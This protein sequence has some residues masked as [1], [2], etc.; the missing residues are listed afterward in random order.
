MDG[1]PAPPSKQELDAIIALDGE[2]VI[3]N[4]KITQCYY[5]LSQAITGRIAGGPA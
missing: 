2:P 1:Q 4:L 3:R 5:D